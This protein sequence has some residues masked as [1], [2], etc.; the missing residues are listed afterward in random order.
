MSTITEILPVATATASRARRSILDLLAPLNRLAQSSA[1]SIANPA[2]QFEVNGAIYELAHFVFLGP[3]AGGEPIR[4]GLF[5]G[6]HG[7]E[8]E[9]AYAPN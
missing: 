1:S 2:G 9:G 3:K 4:V 7:D 8:A 5:V 6:L